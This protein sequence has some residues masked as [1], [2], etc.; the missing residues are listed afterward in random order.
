LFNFSNKLGK[1]VT[2]GTHTPRLDGSVCWCGD[3][4]VYT[5]DSR[6]RKMLENYWRL[7]KENIAGGDQVSSPLH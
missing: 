1:L 5:E 7:P 4:Q 2:D 6:E 3:L